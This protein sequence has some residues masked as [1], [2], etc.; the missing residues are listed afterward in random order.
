MLPVNRNN[1]LKKSH[2]CQRFRKS[3]VVIHRQL[4]STHLIGDIPTIHFYI[5]VLGLNLLCNTNLGLTGCSVTV[6]L[7]SKGCD[8][9]QY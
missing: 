5:F 4:N 2:V 1:L 6:P 7:L 8:E 9:L 3:T